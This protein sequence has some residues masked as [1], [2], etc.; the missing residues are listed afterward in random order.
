[1]AELMANQAH[2]VPVGFSGIH[3][4]TAYGSTRRQAS[5]FVGHGQ[6]SLASD[7]HWPRGPDRTIVHGVSSLARRIDTN[8][9]VCSRSACGA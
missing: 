2:E 7:A 4:P 9:L 8:L 5:R 3:A 1:M 6:S